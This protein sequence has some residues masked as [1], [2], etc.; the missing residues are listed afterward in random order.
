MSFGLLSFLGG[1]VPIRGSLNISVPSAQEQTNSFMTI[2]STG[3]TVTTSGDYKIIAFYG[4]GTMN[5]QS[6]G[7][8]SISGSTLELMMVAGGGGGGRDMGGGGGAGGYYACTSFKVFQTEYTI[9]VGSGGAGAITDGVNPPDRRGANRPGSNGTSSIMSSPYGSF[10]ALGGGGGASRHDGLT[11]YAGSGGSGG[12]GSGQYG[13]HGR[14]LR[15]DMGFT[16]CPSGG[17]WWPGGGGGAGTRGMHGN[18]TA[19]AAGPGNNNS[20][21]A[22]HGGRGVSNSILGPAYWWCGGGGSGA[23]SGHGGNGGTGGGGGGGQAYWAQNQGIGGASGINAGSNGT[24]ASPVGS[25]STG[26]GYSGG[27]AGQYTGGGGG[28][29][30]HITDGGANGATVTS[31]NGGSGI[32]VFKYKFQ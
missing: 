7:I 27:N 23:H 20:N 5:V 30:S 12:G 32:V 14:A 15:G 22:G 29:C 16:G 2:S 3:A 25:T 21:N 28:G 10:E 1:R 6:L 13:N 11:N 9:T 31:G 8:D 26:Q 19:L 17:V 18:E 4:S 24:Q